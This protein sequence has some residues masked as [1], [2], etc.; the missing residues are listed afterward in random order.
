MPRAPI[1]SW[2]QPEKFC[3]TKLKGLK[4]FCWC[5]Y[6]NQMSLTLK[7]SNSMIKVMNAIVIK[8]NK[9]SLKLLEQIAKRMGSEVVQLD[10][11][12]LATIVFTKTP[13]AETIKAINNV[14]NG[15]V[16]RCDNVADLIS[17]LNS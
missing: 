17:K 1:A 3:S 7:C 12:Q 11:E 16:T 13:N 9:K 5:L 10:D 4:R 6:F 14:R 15:K 2:P 8:D